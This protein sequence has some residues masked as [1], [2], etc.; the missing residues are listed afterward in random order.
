MSAI[1]NNEL[2]SKSDKQS[3]S[4]MIEALV[5]I[6]IFSMGILAIVGLQGVAIKTVADSQYRLEA[7]FFANRVVS[8]IWTNVANI[9]D[10]VLPGGGA[11]GLDTWLAEVQSRLPGATG[12]NAPTITIAANPSGGFTATIAIM[13][14]APGESAPH[15]FTTVAYINPNP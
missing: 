4:V 5:A 1:S 8:D 10:Y 14:Q 13:W 2:S 9:N 12:A 3:G 11:T 7:S 6:L 15:N